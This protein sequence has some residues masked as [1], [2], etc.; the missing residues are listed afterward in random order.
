MNILSKIRTQSI[1][2]KEASCFANILGNRTIPKELIPSLNINNYINANLGTGNAD[3][4]GWHGYLQQSSLDAM[5][6]GLE[7][8][9]TNAGS[10]KPRFIF[11]NTSQAYNSKTISKVILNNSGSGFTLAPIITI[12]GDGVGATAYAIMNG[13]KISEI[14]VNKGGKNYTFAN[15]TISGGGGAGAVATPYIASG[16]IS[17]NLIYVEENSVFSKLNPDGSYNGTEYYT[18]A[19]SND[20]VPNIGYIPNFGLLLHNQQST[21][22]GNAIVIA[23][24]SFN[25]KTSKIGIFQTNIQIVYSVFGTTSPNEN[26]TL[27]LSVELCDNLGFAT[28]VYGQNRRFTLKNN[29]FGVTGDFNNTTQAY[30][31]LTYLFNDFGFMQNTENTPKTYYFRVT[32]KIISMTA[33]VNTQINVQSDQTGIFYTLYDPAIFDKF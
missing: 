4:T 29:K 20:L 16:Q 6:G 19:Q 28:N 9:P 30:Y 24:K 31:N 14:R 10:L 22:N 33:P 26:T 8:T 13:D 1:F 18:K 11:G 17:S 7:N 21:P 12:T 15:I 3:D 2:S 5:F 32:A 27:E 23:N 25:I